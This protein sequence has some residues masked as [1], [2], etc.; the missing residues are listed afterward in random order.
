MMIKL[1]I[2]LI[3]LFLTAG[4]IFLPDSLAFAAEAVANSAGSPDMVQPSR[5]DYP[6]LG[7][8]SSR[9]LAWGLAQMHLLLAAFVLAVPLF[10][11][12]IELTGVLMK[13]DRYDDMAHE[14]MKIS[15]SAYSLTAL[16][17]GALTI[18]LFLLYPHL[19]GYLMKVFNGQMLWYAAL[20]LMES[21]CLYTYYY[22]WDAMR[23]GRRKWA[24]L[25]I[26]LLLNTIGLTLMYVANAWASF[27]MSPTGIEMATGAITGGV[28]D[29]TRNPLWN[30]INLHRFLANIAYGGAIVGA[31]AAY[32]FMS[33]SKAE[34]KA[35]YD[36]MGYTSNIIA[37]VGFLPLPFA[38]YWLMAEIYAYSQQMGITAMGGVLAW[39]FIIQAV[40]IGTILLAANYYLWCGLGRTDRG[41][42]YNRY[43]KY[44]AFVLVAGFLVWLT[45]HSL[46]LTA[47]EVVLLGGTHHSILGPLGIMPAKNIAVNLMLVFTF[48]S[49]QMFYRSNRIATV[50]WAK[51]GQAVVV[52]L[53]VVGCLNI[54]AAG[55]Y[56]YFTPTV[57]KVGAS[58]PQVVTTLSIIVFAAT[59]DFFMLRGSKKTEIHWGRMPERSQYALF[60]L[61]IAFTWL[62]CL[63]GY[64]RSSLRGHWHVYTVMKDK[65][66]EAFIPTMGD[67]G[68][69]I[70]VIT[71]LFMGVIVFV[72]WLSQMG[73]TKQLKPGSK[74]A[75]SEGEAST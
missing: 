41:E 21:V 3:V 43:I 9:N 45:P 54:I 23:W 68:I 17:G 19:M 25:C 5:A 20:F 44:I 51:S 36:W 59:I 13:D 75:V 69:V 4:S 11:L 60:V 15:M 57:Y 56:G 26:S 39:L 34:V 18:A 63:M 8:I 48:L 62:M 46:V 37:V 47:E 30:P 7:F 73:A 64:I 16:A 12:C 32:R 70:T 14:F 10:V 71:L 66:P 65:S 52:A 35:H 38:G 27:M 22:T 61:P 31:Y 1:H 33:E 42:K 28:W 2:L 53:Y 67:A 55:V 24:H 72:F 74:M 58:V 6:S 29:A 49:F 50:S 40:L